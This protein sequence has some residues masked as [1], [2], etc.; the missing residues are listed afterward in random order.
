MTTYLSGFINEHHL[1]AFTHQERLSMQHYLVNEP[2]DVSLLF[3]YHPGEV[4]HQLQQ[5]ASA[6]LRTIAIA[7]H[8]SD[9]FT[10]TPLHGRNTA[11]IRSHYVHSTPIALATSTPANYLQDGRACIGLQMSAWHGSAIPV[12]ILQANVITRRSASPALC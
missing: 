1:A 12:D 3:E 9:S 7:H 8:T 2:G 6:Y 5:Q 4:Q 10:C 11:M